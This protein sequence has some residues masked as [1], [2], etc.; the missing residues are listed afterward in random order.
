GDDGAV[1][2]EDGEDWSGGRA[3]EEEGETGGRRARGV[4]SAA[5][6]PRLHSPQRFITAK[7]RRPPL[8]FFFPSYL[9]LCCQT[10][11]ISSHLKSSRHIRLSLLKPSRHATFVHH[12]STRVVA[13]RS[14]TANPAERPLLLLPSTII[15]LDFCSTASSL[16]VGFE[17]RVSHEADRQGARR[18]RKGH[19]GMPSFIASTH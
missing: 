2:K 11:R 3:K 1:G 19:M 12:E 9:H 5:V 13:P 6:A 8:I 18:M 15:W 17:V 16:I 7:R 14:S 4:R 10:C